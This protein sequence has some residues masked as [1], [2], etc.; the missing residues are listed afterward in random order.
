MKKYLCLFL[1]LL[2][3]FVS[4]TEL[5]ATSENSFS[6]IQNNKNEFTV[7]DKQE[8]LSFVDFNYDI[9]GNL[10]SQVMDSNHRLQQIISKDEAGNISIKDPKGNLIHYINASEIETE[11]ES[12]IVPYATQFCS[13]VG[14]KG[15]NIS[16]N[17]SFQSMITT[18]GTFIG[19][20]SLIG[21][22]GTAV[23]TIVTFSAKVRSGV[24]AIVSIA[25]N[26]GGRH[27][28]G[29]IRFSG[30]KVCLQRRGGSNAY[31]TYV[32]EPNSAVRYR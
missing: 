7:V 19:I 5:Y 17:I 32:F 29:G 11:K 15:G 20:A 14:Q 30:P 16:K 10:Y 3:L 25:L 13:V 21:V 27:A 22:V 31:K 26:E 1:S 2:L 8:G 24:N 12:S 4:S 18:A 28:K 23:G 6:I 9:N